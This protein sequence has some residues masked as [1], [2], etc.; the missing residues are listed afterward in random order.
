MLSSYPRVYLIVCLC[1]GVC[2][3]CV[4]GGGGGGEG[5]SI[6]ESFSFWILWTDLLLTKVASECTRSLATMF[7][8]Q[9]GYFS[10][11]QVGTH[12]FNNFQ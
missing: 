11:L 7:P 2:C 8:L 5:I 12:K 4:C 6:P 1:V 10:P 9:L 3:V